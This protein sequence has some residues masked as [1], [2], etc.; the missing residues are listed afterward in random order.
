MNKE[1]K[2]YQRNEYIIITHY[3][4]FIPARSAGVYVGPTRSQV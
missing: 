4:P 1:H 2:Y 3:L